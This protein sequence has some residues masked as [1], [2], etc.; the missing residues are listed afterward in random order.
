MAILNEVWYALHVHVNTYIHVQVFM[1]IG[2]N[3]VSP[4]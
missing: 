1:Q 3:E 4:F 2:H